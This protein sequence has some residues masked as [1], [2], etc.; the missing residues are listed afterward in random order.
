M[1]FRSLVVAILLVVSAAPTATQRAFAQPAADTPELDPRVVKLSGIVVPVGQ[2]GRLA[3]YLF[4]SVDIRVADGVDPWSVRDKSAIIRDALVRAAHRNAL[5]DPAN[6][7][8][9]N[10]ALAQRVFTQ[11]AAAAVPRSIAWVRVTSVD[12]LRR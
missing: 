12:S 3:N 1:L 6:V 8:R 5:G 10:T 7:G 2:D 9:L 4:A 11:A